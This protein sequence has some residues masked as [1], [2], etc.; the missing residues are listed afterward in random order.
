MNT[1]LSKAISK[2]ALILFISFLVSTCTTTHKVHPIGNINLLE[3]SQSPKISSAVSR[4]Y[5]LLFGGRKQALVQEATTKLSSTYVGFM[6]SR[7][8][9]VCIDDQHSTFLGIITEHK[10][11]ISANMVLKKPE[12]GPEFAQAIKTIERVGFC[13]G[14]YVAFE[15]IGIEVD[16][17]LQGKITGFAGKMAQIELIHKPD[18]LT[19]NFTGVEHVK[20]LKF[21]E[22]SALNLQ[23]GNNVSF[24]PR[25]NNIIELIGEITDVVN[26]NEV[27]VKL[28]D[29]SA[30]LW[31][32]AGGVISESDIATFPAFRL[33]RR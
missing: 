16:T 2:L 9:N 23:V 15:H 13:I 33:R 10:V 31:R 8:E 1:L 21:A 30:A 20:G 6:P 11:I 29:A 27:K 5:F 25:G 28:D 3:A 17:W 14:D 24:Y 7:L 12:A 22:A 4:Q 19:P 26:N 18:K 32:K